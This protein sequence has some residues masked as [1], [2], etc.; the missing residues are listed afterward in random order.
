V[1]ENQASDQS[2]VWLRIQNNSI[3]AHIINNLSTKFWLKNVEADWQGVTVART[4]APDK[5]LDIPITTVKL[6][7][8]PLRYLQTELKFD[9]VYLSV[10]DS[11]VVIA[12]LPPQ[13]V[14]AVSV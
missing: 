11:K 8:D 9:K 12:L 7:G 14:P 6:D 5:V 10:D 4:L 2:I 13:L 1:L 3:D